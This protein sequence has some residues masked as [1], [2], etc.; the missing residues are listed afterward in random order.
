M[1]SSNGVILAFARAADGKLTL[2]SCVNDIGDGGCSNGKGASFPFYLTVSPDGAELFA[3]SGSS[4]LTVYDRDAT[5]N[6][7][8]RT[9]QDVCVTG[10]G[11]VV[12]GG[13]VVA[14]GCRSH[15]AV[16]SN[17]RVTFASNDQFYAGFYGPGSVVAF[18][19]DF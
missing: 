1:A 12:D 4:G 19:R 5:G 8:Q 11:G 9:G 16:G 7:S 3:T 6:L 2:Q 17:G 15:P 14:G 18:K 10:D 13:V